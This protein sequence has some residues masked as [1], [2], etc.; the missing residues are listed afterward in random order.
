[1]SVIAD[2]HIHIYPFYDIRLALDSLRNNLH[3]LDPDASCMAFLA[4]RHDCRFFRDFSLNASVMLGPQVRV[5]VLDAVLRVRETGLRDLYIVAGRQ[6]ITRE[7]IEILALMTDT[8]M[9]DN[10]PARDV[11]AE[12]RAGRGIPVLGWA[13]GKWFFAR[14][15]VIEA[16]LEENE[17]GTLLIGDTTLRP[18]GWPMPVLMNKAVRKGFTL[19][20]GSDPLPFPGEEAMAGRYASRLAATL[21]PGNPLASIRTLL[22]TPGY[23]P[24]HAGKRGNPW[25]TMLRLFKNAMAKKGK[26][27]R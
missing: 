7:R 18:V 14:K 21:D 10:Q 19:V 22:T 9:D 1:M 16:I 27:V 24:S 20:A 13:P 3:A 26:S 4:E 25:Q 15:K 23:V 6:I 12:V 8:I 5:D 11:I 2:T 17:P